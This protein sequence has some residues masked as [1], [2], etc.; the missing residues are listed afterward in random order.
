[1]KR[2]CTILTVITAS[3]VL[4]STASAEI[5]LSAGGGIHFCMDN[6]DFE[7]DRQNVGY[8]FRVGLDYR[9]VRH[10]DIMIDKTAPSGVSIAIE[11]D[12]AWEN[13]ETTTGAGKDLTINTMHGMLM[14]LYFL[15]PQGDPYGGY[16]GAGGGYARS[17]ISGTDDFGRE[18]EATWSSF[19]NIKL[20]IG[21]LYPVTSFFEIGA[22]FDYFFHFG[23][24]VCANVDGGKEVCSDVESD[25]DVASNL[26]AGLLFRAGF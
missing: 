24:E 5:G 20:S 18:V 2:I 16:L 10:S 22:Y 13:G 23:G 25:D 15:R 26:Q 9:F 4:T 1:M 12:D 11:F 17:A 6:G 3:I 19:M 21:L 7:C 8:G 14:V